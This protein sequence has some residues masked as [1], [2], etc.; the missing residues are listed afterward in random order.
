VLSRE[1]VGDL[2]ARAY[3]ATALGD[4]I[5]H[6]RTETDF[7]SGTHRSSSF[8]E[9]WQY[10]EEVHWIVGGSLNP[11]ST[12]EHYLGK[13]DVVRTTIHQPGKPD[14]HQTMTPEFSAEARDIIDGMQ[15][16]F[17]ERFRSFYRE[18]RIRDAGR[19]TFAGRPAQR[20]VVE[21][22][23]GSTSEY[24]IDAETV[25]PLGRVEHDR[26]ARLIERVTVLEALPPT[27]QSLAKV[28]AP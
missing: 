3:A 15:G 4:Q 18:D 7:V 22:P 21:R 2:A 14:Q 13:D 8:S 27:P 1:G 16:S 25:L 6:Y 17:V 11:G 12:F 10:A 24:F 5:R 28:R 26:G 9:A 23:D 19:T 20:Y